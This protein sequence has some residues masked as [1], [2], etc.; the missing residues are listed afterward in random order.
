MHRRARR[1]HR[2]CTGR[3][4]HDRVNDGREDAMTPVLATSRSLERP[5]AAWSEEV[6]AWLV[7]VNGDIFAAIPPDEGVT[8]AVYR[9][10][11]LT[12]AVGRVSA[13]RGLL[14]HG[15]W[16]IQNRSGSPQGGGDG[17]V[18]AHDGAGEAGGHHQ[19]HGSSDEAG[20]AADLAT[21]GVR[22][23]D[24]DRCRHGDATAAPPVVGGRRL[25]RGWGRGVHIY[26]VGP[27]PPRRGGGPSGARRGRRYHRRWTG[28]VRRPVRGGGG[29]T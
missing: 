7:T 11:R 13:R 23:V 19:P 2:R 15:L 27:P 14:P 6:V 5:W 10:E 16:R 12:G 9:A 3:T 24:V 1:V 18:P 26:D 29:P 20:S 25:R 28:P 4:R 22:T 8:A 21:R 17:P